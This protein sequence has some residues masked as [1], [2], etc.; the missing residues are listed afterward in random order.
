MARKRRRLRIVLI[1]GASLFLL[2]ALGWFFGPSG[3]V[4]GVEFSPDRFCHRSF[5]YHLWCGI[6][7]TPKETHQW[8]SDL[9]EY[10]HEQGFVSSADAPNPRWLLVKGFK[11]FVRGWFGEAKF[12]CQAVD[13]YGG[14]SNRWVTWSKDHPELAKVLWP[15]VVR[16]ARNDQYAE[17]GS[18]ILL[19]DLEGVASAEDLR[20]KIKQAERENR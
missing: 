1:A 9:E 15:Q 16:W 4:H 3:T 2:V 20:K 8:R 12:L 14:G 5:R 19:I 13:C 7:I 18:L 17:I 11:P 10:L 6:Q